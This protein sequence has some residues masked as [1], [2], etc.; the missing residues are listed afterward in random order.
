[1]SRKAE[2]NPERALEPLH[3]LVVA[4]KKELDQAEPHSDGFFYT[5]KSVRMRVSQA[6]QARALKIVDLVIRTLE[7]HGFEVL[8][9]KQNA[10]ERTGGAWISTDVRDIELI[11]REEMK[12]HDHQLT[13]EEAADFKRT[14]YSWAPKYDWKGTGNIFVVFEAQFEPTVSIK[15]GVRWRQE[16]RIPKI[17]EALKDMVQRAREHDADIERSRR[18]YEEEQKRIV[19]EAEAREKERERE[20]NLIKTMTSWQHA[21]GIRAFVSAAQSKRRDQVLG[22][23]VGGVEF[24]RWVRWALS[25]A[26]KIDPLVEGA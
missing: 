10:Q 1:V 15:E 19:E 26:D 9:L 14:G 12:R 2:G 8:I 24:D 6:S 7:R 25:Y 20:E 16:E 13:A 3:P 21:Q 17:V 4:T 22:D 18:E 23:P 5:W 11:I